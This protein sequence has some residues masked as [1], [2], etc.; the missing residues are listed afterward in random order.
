[1]TGGLGNDV[2]V[3]DKVGDKVIETSTLATE[4]DSVN[5]S[6]S[7]TLAANVENLTLTGTA[8]VNG[9]GNGLANTLIGNTANNLL[10]G[11]AGNDTL[12]GAAGNDKLDGGTGNDA[13]TGGAGLDIFRFTTAPT[14]N[15]DTL[16]D[17]SVADDTLQLENAVFKK[18][19]SPGVLKA[20]NFVKA[21]AAHDLNDYL[22]YNPATGALSYDAD[23]GGVGA[24]QQIALLGVN[25]ALTNA[26]FVII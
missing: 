17:F 22:V 19:A 11:N 4:I 26:D 12:S 21:G 9:K 15:V 5:S 10:L 7:Y 25:L 16:T 24:A 3:V 20:A 14:A 8:A 23:G 13:L 1:M 2:Y 18:L 6:V